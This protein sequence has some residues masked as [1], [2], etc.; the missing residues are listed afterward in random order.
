[1]VIKIEVYYE[2]TRETKKPFP[3]NSKILLESLISEQCP[4]TVKLSGSWFTDDRVIATKLT[5]EALLEKIRT[6]K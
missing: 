2:L 5:R 1:M 4:E 3:E 6:A